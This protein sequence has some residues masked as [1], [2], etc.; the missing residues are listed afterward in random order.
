[1]KTYLITVPSTVVALFLACGFL[2]AQVPQLTT[3]QEEGFGLRSTHKGAYVKVY[4]IKLL[5]TDAQ[6]KLV[7]RE[8]KRMKKAFP[9]ARLIRSA[10]QFNYSRNCHDYAWAGYMSC[11]PGGD[12][13]PQKE[14]WWMGWRGSDGLYGLPNLNWLDGS[15][16]SVAIGTKSAPTQPYEF[17]FS[18]SDLD[19]LPTTYYDDR[20]LGV[21]LPVSDVQNLAT[22]VPSHS[23]LLVGFHPSSKIPSD[24][25]YGVYWSKWGA[26]G[27]WQ[28]RWGEP[29]C[30]YGSTTIQ[31]FAPKSPWVP[32][33][34]IVPTA[35]GDI[36]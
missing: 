29:F 19:P 35:W 34:L 12:L 18:Q 17:L 15:M 14:A 11:C 10:T 4:R 22:D 9:E 32:P 2:H 5:W 36:P 23:A 3:Y 25:Y 26:M 6:K 13:L 16:A 20:V 28:H 7:K 24:K 27:V 8:E 31:V 33:Y 21:P 30:P 1:M